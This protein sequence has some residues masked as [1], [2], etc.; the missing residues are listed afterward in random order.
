MCLA[1][2][3]TREVKA[4]LLSPPR[5]R[6]SLNLEPRH[7]QA[8]TSISSLKHQRRG[9]NEAKTEFRLH[10]HL[11]PTHRTAVAVPDQLVNLL[12]QGKKMFYP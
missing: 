9:P 2:W 5:G 7:T 4:S 10:L 11:A 6:S 1:S 12:P 3:E 8:M